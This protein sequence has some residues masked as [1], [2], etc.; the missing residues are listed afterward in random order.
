MANL[1]VAVITV[2]LILAAMA[3]LVQS[4]VVPQG[5]AAN[6]L[7][8]MRDRT[9]EIARTAMA[10]LGV[11]VLAGGSEVELTV[12]NDGQTPLRAFSA[13]DLLISYE[14]GAGL[15]I[16]RLT[17]TSDAAPSSGEW[18]VTG[19]YSDA[20]AMVAE[21]FQPGI[22]NTGEEFVI[23]A[24]LDPAISSPSDNSLVLAVDNGVA[25]T[26]TFTN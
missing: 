13:W 7:K 1:F 14:A 17:Y 15:Q 24:V 25:L 16:Q 20:S 8:T 6:S 26:V 21:V 22:V 4:S 11:T 18:T 12:R 5:V 19:I 10:S 3:G 2:A 9:G 23:K